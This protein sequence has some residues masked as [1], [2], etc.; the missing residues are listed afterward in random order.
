[1]NGQGPRVNKLL[2]AAHSD[3]HPHT[4]ELMPLVQELCA[5][6]RGCILVVSGETEQS[7]MPG[8]QGGTGNYPSQ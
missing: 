1:M 6:T 4:P 8:K 3:G 2:S 5:T 7:G